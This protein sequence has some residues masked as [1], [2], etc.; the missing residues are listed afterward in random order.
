MVVVQLLMNVVYVQVMVFG[1]YVVAAVQMNL[2]YPMA[3]VIVM[4]M[5][6]TVLDYAVEIRSV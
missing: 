2:E 3:I 1:R 6:W 4:A 5:Y